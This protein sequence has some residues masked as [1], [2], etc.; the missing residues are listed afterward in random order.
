[1]FAAELASMWVTAFAALSTVEP[2]VTSTPAFAVV[3]LTVV[4]MLAS[5]A[6]L[7]Q[8]EL[9]TSWISHEPEPMFALEPAPTQ[10]PGHAVQSMQPTTELVVR[11]MQRTPEPVML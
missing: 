1:M 4:P 7:G 8:T 5:V 10:E 9:A 6:A 3:Q 11:W 2:G